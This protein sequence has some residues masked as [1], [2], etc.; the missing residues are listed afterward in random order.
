MH[1]QALASADSNST[2]HA[3]LSILAKGQA[4]SVNRYL[5]KP[6][7]PAELAAMIAQVQGSIDRPSMQR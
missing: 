2:A 7:K 4:I 1:G 5:S 6:V 3:L